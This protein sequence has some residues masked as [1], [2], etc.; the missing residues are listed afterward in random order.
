MRSGDMV[1]TTRWVGVAVVVAGF[2]CGCGQ[3]GSSRSESSGAT[4][5]SSDAGGAS[6][7]VTHVFAYTSGTTIAAIRTRIVSIANLG[8]V[9]GTCTDGGRL[10]TRFD[11]FSK[12]P[13]TSIVVTVAPGE[14]VHGTTTARSLT[15]PTGP[16]AAVSHTWQ[17]APITS[18]TVRVA[19][20]TLTAQPA[21]AAF[22]GRGC[23][24]AAHATVTTQPP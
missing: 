20:I 8:T 19:T 23:V 15:A 10:S 9:T 13:T 7:P 24:V 6:A 3:T 11:L 14:P 2:A 22:G 12:A 21:P 16:A 4:P 18:A 1:R 5:V 17:I